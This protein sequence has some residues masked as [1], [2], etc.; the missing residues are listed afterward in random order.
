MVDDAIRFVSQKSKSE[1]GSS[2]DERGDDEQVSEEPDYDED[3]DQK[4]SDPYNMK[5]FWEMMHSN[6]IYQQYLFPNDKPG[7]VSMSTQ[8]LFYKYSFKVINKLLEYIVQ[9][10]KLTVYEDGKE[11]GSML[12]PNSAASV[13]Q[14][15][16]KYSKK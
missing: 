12:D 7:P 1:I 11:K 13:I 14:Q 8:A 16:S 2:N 3:Q 10:S 15:F 4:N 6:I 5:K 9:G